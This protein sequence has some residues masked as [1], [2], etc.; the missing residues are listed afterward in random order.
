MQKK[1][2]SIYRLT[3]IALMA[4]MVYM[5][6]NF[7]ID[8]PTPLG[9]TMLHLGNVMCILSG[10]LFGGWIGGLAS[11]IGSAF[12]DLLDPSFAPGFMITFFMKFALG[13]AA[14]AIAHY[15]GAR[16]ENQK[17]NLVGAIAGALL[18]VILYI[19]KT[20][21]AKYLIV[22]EHLEVVMSVVVIKGTVSLTNA[23]IAV[24]TSMIL[25]ILI[26]P[27]LRSAGILKKIRRAKQ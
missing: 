22:G 19:A 3:V 16:G 6:T 12:Y 9:K 1:K 27:P 17:Q 18:Y 5:A 15:N 4:A 13:A 23:V 24:V 2:S 11:G 20:F 7:R 25:S 26:V 14:G 8:I 21:V 10:L